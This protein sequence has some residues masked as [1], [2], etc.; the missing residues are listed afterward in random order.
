VSDI[1][2]LA[3]IIVVPTMYLSCGFSDVTACSITFA[4]SSGGEDNDTFSIL[5]LNDSLPFA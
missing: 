3:C 2:I 1:L 5:D 4:T